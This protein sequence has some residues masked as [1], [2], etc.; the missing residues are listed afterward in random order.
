[1]RRIA[2]LVVVLVSLTSLAAGTET[3][4]LTTISG[5]KVTGTLKSWSDG[6][7][8]LMAATEQKFARSEIRS[9]EFPRPPGNSKQARPE[10]WLSNG[11][12]ISARAV[13]VANDL[14]AISWP[15]MNESEL[16]KI[17]LEKVLAIVLEWPDDTSDRLRLISDLQTLPP[18]NDL[19]V[20]ANGDRSLGEFVRLDAAHVELK[21][22]AKV[23]KL[24]RSRTRAIRFNPELTTVQRPIDRRVMLTLND[25]SLLTA[26][27][28]EFSGDAFQVN[29]PAL[30]SLT[31][32]A[33]S[34]VACHLFGDRLVPLSDYEP[35][36]VKFTPYL[37]SHWPL[38]YNANVRRGRL[39]LRGVESGVGLGMHSRMEVSYKLNGREREFQ[40]TVGIDD[41]AMGKGSVIFA[42]DLDGTRAWTS[43]ELTGKSPAMT[44][45][46][47]DVRGKKELTLI[48]DFGEF[49]DVSD[50][51]NWCDAVLVIDA[52]R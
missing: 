52:A 44:I 24:D 3:V 48:V 47:I 5:T 25:G 38:I 46:V 39:K 34:L 11:D 42:V 20:L 21:L 15:I 18:G 12:R 19:I 8:V 30:G 26:S 37:S 41:I 6:S 32:P 51:A 4:T 33:T 36:Q 28:I 9:V 23:L 27:S 45:P 43:P 49:A 14:L 16:A 2:F 40:A 7:V 1:M 50:Y 22:G 10:I 31:L 17:S 29:S 13:T 35:S